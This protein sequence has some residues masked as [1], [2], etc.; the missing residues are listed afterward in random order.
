MDVQLDRRVTALASLLGKGPACL[1][2]EREFDA[3]GAAEKDLVL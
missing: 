1:E 3:D 2:L